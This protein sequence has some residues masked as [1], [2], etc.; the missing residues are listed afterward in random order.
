[1]KK[2]STRRVG[3]GPFSPFTVDDYRESFSEAKLLEVLTQDDT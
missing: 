1:M 3:A 2:S